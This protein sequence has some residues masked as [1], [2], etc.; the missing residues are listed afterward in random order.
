MLFCFPLAKLHQL[1]FSVPK[2]LQSVI[3]RKGVNMPLSQLFFLSV[4]EA[5]SP[6]F[7]YI[8]QLELSSSAKTLKIFSLSFCLVNKGSSK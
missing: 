3:K 1:I 6:K 2:W 7:V 8:L 5:S 4:L